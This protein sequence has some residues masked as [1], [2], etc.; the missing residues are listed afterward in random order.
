MICQICIC[1]TQVDDLIL[2]TPKKALT[3]LINSIIMTFEKR[4]EWLKAEHEALIARKN[5]A[6][7]GNGVYERYRFPILTGDHAP[8]FWR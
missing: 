5:E 2:Y 6:I 7:E 3:L 1:Q 8:L 4:L